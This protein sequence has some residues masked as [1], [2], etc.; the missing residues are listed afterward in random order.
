M[1]TSSTGPAISASTPAVELPTEP[2]FSNGHAI[3][4]AT[5]IGPSASPTTCCRQEFPTHTA[6]ASLHRDLR[7]AWRWSCGFATA[8]LRSSGAGLPDEIAGVT[9]CFLRDLIPPGSNR[10]GSGGSGAVLEAPALVA[11]L[12]DVPQTAAT[13]TSPMPEIVADTPDPFC[14]FSKAESRYLLIRGCSARG[15]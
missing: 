13:G 14:C 10:A 2:P 15:V 4:L 7:T 3:K 9:V 12:D 1:P 6:T 5:R 11:G 8:T